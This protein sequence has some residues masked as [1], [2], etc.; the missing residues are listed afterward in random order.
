MRLLKDSCL[1]DHHYGSCDIAFCC[2]KSTL[3]FVVYFRKSVR[4]RTIKTKAT[5][6]MATM[7][8]MNQY[9]ESGTNADGLVTI[10]DVDG[11]AVGE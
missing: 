5:T 11:A 4:L 1:D 2:I 8:M 6:V 7:M 3:V 10:A 9:N